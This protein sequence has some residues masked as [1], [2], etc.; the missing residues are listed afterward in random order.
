MK[1]KIFLILFAI[2]VISY[3]LVISTSKKDSQALI[4]Y[5]ANVTVIERRSGKEVIA[6]INDNSEDKLTVNLSIYSNIFDVGDKLKVEYYQEGRKYFINK[7]DPLITTNNEKLEYQKK[8]SSDP[9]VLRFQEQINREIEVD[10][11]LSLILAMPDT[12][13]GQSY[14][15]MNPSE[16]YK[17]KFQNYNSD[18]FIIKKDE[19]T[20]IIGKSSFKVISFQNYFQEENV[21]IN[22]KYEDDYDKDKI[23]FKGLGKGI[24][25]LKIEFK[26]KDVINY[27]FI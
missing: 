23:I 8:I 20:K 7:I 2:L 15:T 24:Y 13:K 14:M 11:M 10:N 5:N 27:I 26:N 6:K 12:I 17:Y 4:I 18:D 25:N 1:V 16:F 21:N 22:Y 19:E 3:A 9:T